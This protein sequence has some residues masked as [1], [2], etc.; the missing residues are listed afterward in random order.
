MAPM[1]VAVASH[2]RLPVAGYGGTQR[3]VVAL[4]RGLAALGHRVTLLAQPGT[5]VAEASALV[6]LPPK[7]LRDP[8]LDLTPFVPKDAD[9]LHVH[10]PVAKPPQRPFVQTLHGNHRKG[11]PVL[12][13]TIFLSQDHAR[14]HGST[15]WVYNG[16]DPADYFFRRRK[17]N[18]DLFL[19]RL[20]SAKG[21]HWAI[22][23]AKKSGRKLIIAGGWR[24]SFTGA[25]KYVGEVDGKRKAALLARARCLWNAAQWDEPFG[26]VTIEALFS[27]TPVLATRRGALPEIIT[28][29]TGALC[30]TLAEMLDASEHI[31]TRDPAA[32][33][34]HAERHFTHRVMAAE[35]VRMYRG[36]LDTGELPA[37]Q[38]TS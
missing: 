26:L 35:Y 16:L 13:H 32:C 31:G 12:P 11:D 29:A 18:W 33:R 25:I 14:R 20:H 36:L 4:V 2:H 30:D 22:E 28:P 9:I 8:A 17:E 21:Y 23:A 1:H 15:T 34:A 6:E 19:G 27:G 3:V 37:G 7:R 5:T 10:F 38:T 24:P